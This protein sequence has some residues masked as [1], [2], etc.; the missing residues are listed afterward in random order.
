M[1]FEGLRSRHLA[2]A[3]LGKP[4]AKNKARG[5]WSLLLHAVSALGCTASSARL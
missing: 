1:L 3:G 2:V 4:K 5:N